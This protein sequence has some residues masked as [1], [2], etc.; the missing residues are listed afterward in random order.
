MY[1]PYLATDCSCRIFQKTP[2]SSA[3]N[4]K[5]PNDHIMAQ[6]HHGSIPISDMPPSA[7]AL[8]IFPDHTY[9]PLLSLGQLADAGYKFHGDNTTLMLTHPLHQD[10]I[11]KR[12]FSSG[13]YL[14]SL[15]NPHSA[16]PTINQS[17]C[18][19]HHAN[20]TRLSQ[21]S[22]HSVNNAYSMTT[23]PDLAMYYY[24]A[25]FS[26]VP[27]TFISAIKKGYFSSW[28]GL[29]AEL[30]S[31]HMPTSLATAKGHSKLVRKNVRSTRPILSQPGVL[32]HLVEK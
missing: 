8:K 30:I 13:M 12:C 9:K 16:L 23:K 14:L 28:P 25:D 21:P 15:T 29:T 31:K 7:K 26:P 27:S 3:I 6:S 20:S 22:S 24:R 18:H 11:A 10:L 1:F 5:L 4:V 2:A 19:F 17:S 32:P